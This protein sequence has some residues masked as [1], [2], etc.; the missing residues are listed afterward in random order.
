MV[1]ASKILTVSYGTFSCTL[2][3][4]DDPFSTMRSIA[5][6]FR[7]LA[8]DDRYFGAEPPTP[9]AEMLHRI[10]EREVKRRVESRVGDEGIVLRQVEDQGRNPEPSAASVAA[11]L[12]AAA[13]SA[14][15]EQSDTEDD[16]AAKAGADTPE[17]DPAVEEARESYAEDEEAA[18]HAESVSAV[19]PAAPETGDDSVAAKLSRIRAVVARSPSE[20]PAGATTTPFGGS[21]D[22]AFADA[23]DADWEDVVDVDITATEG[24]VD[25]SGEEAPATEDT[26]HEAATSI[27]AE[28]E[29]DDKPV[30]LSEAQTLAEM[31]Q[32]TE[33]ESIPDLA[34]LD[35]QPAHNTDAE[36]MDEG[37][38]E[39]ASADEQETTEVEDPDDMHLG[40]AARIVKL[41]RAAVEMSAQQDALEN[42]PEQATDTSELSGALADQDDAALEGAELEDEENLFD[43]AF[44]DV[45]EE[46]QNAETALE[47]AQDAFEDG[48]DAAEEPKSPIATIAEAREAALLDAESEGAT[49]TPAAPGEPEARHAGF[50]PEDHGEDALDRILEQTNSRMDDTEGSRRRS[51]IAH[52]KAAVAATKADRL[53]NRETRTDE[54]AKEQSAYRNDLAQVVQSHPEAEA[55][56]LAEAASTPDSE[57]DG[58]FLADQDDQSSPLVL[59]SGQRVD[60]TD[61]LAD[62]D[63]DADD[64]DEDDDLS[65]PAASIMP[66]RVNHAEG[67]SQ[68]HAEVD[69]EGFADFAEKLGVTELPDL[70]EAAA[71][72]TAFVEGNKLFS[73]PQL[74]RRVATFE[75][76]DE[77]SREAGLRSFGQLL[78]QGK[79]QKLKRGQFTITEETRFNPEARMAGE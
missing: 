13:A 4:F 31:E 63:L 58:P 68:V 69:E 26:S 39:A 23:E 76:G 36:T 20:E 64:E 41:K 62:D 53:L 46:V 10:A 21:I 48:D 43:G 71:A 5:E 17:V 9:D 65:V 28:E 73:R 6:Y 2:E 27:A 8:A 24:P 25:F 38:R 77:F 55:D 30:D 7:D 1:G 67:G 29:Y 78:R 52:L 51:A 72:Y 32:A 56:D 37:H 11:G 12:A 40:L 44:E 59:V 18:L 49:E 14:G 47:A 34:A 61:D 33:A 45:P 66:R 42:G 57:D 3:G 54:T 19:A 75:T 50:D 22:A 16:I 60:V 35:T 74:M 79:I 70:L 15:S